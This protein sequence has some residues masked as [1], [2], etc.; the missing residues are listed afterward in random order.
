MIIKQVN[1]TDNIFPACL[2]F[3]DDILNQKN[4]GV[5]DNQTVWTLGFGQTSYNGRA[6]DLLREADL[7]IVPQE[8]CRKAFQHLI[9]LSSEYVC[10]SSQQ[11]SELANI[12]ERDGISTGDQPETTNLETSQD[13]KQIE[14][15]ARVKDS[16]QGDSGG[17]LM[18]QSPERKNGRWYVY[19]IVSFGFR[20]ATLGF[21]G[22]Y[23]RVNHYLSWI[24]G[25]L[26]Q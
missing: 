17:P 6:S 15:K 10:A 5:V 23:T 26:A 16:C 4:P 2:P 20:C 14:R 22:V 21:P 1:F 11:I 24:D 3:D 13:S 12:N 7:A 8:S 9:N 19:G 25:Q 18:M